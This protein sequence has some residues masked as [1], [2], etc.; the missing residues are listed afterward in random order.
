MTTR[1]WIISAAVFF[2]GLTVGGGVV[3]SYHQLHEK[4]TA[5]DFSRRL[6]CNEIANQYAKRQSSDTQ[7]VSVAMTGYSAASN[8]C[9]AY[10]QTWNHIAANYEVREWQVMDVLSGEM[11]NYET[12]TVQS[13]DCGHGN[14]TKFEKESRAAFQQAITGHEVGTK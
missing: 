11:R 2:I 7:S 1:G 8:S 9:V 5:E 14:D 10:F 3:E 4:K 6:R 13:G 12:C